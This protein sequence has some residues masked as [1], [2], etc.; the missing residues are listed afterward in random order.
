MKK[1]RVFKVTT[2]LPI[3][4]SAMFSLV[5]AAT[6]DV[7]NLPSFCSLLLFMLDMLNAGVVIP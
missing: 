4:K 5:C 1:T 6:D 3:I 7:R 2:A